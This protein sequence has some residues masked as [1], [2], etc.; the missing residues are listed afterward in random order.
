MGEQRFAAEN[1]QTLGA[2]QGHLNDV[3]FEIP[4]PKD[5]HATD[6]DATALWEI[7]RRRM[8]LDHHALHAEFAQTYRGRQPDG[9]APHDEHW[10]LYALHPA[11]AESV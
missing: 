8:A 7:E 2:W 1:E 5:L 11:S 9:P 10:C 4:L 3:L 6:G